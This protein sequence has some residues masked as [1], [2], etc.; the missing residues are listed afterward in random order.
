VTLPL[1]TVVDIGTNTDEDCYQFTLDADAL[2]AADLSGTCTSSED[3]EIFLLDQA[4]TELGRNDDD[5]SSLCSTL[6]LNLAAGTYR[7]CVI[8]HNQD[9]VAIGVDMTITA[10]APAT[11]N[12]RNAPATGSNSFSSTVTLPSG[13]ESCVSVSV[14]AGELLTASAADETCA[15]FGRSYS[16]DV[17]AA[18]DLTTSVVSTF[19]GGGGSCALLLEATVPAGDYVVCFNENNEVYTPALDVQILVQTPGTLPSGSP[20]FVEATQV[21][22]DA[23]NNEQCLS[24]E[25]PNL[26][27]CGV[28]NTLGEGETCVVG[29]TGAVC[30]ANLEC[31]G[32]CL[33][34]DGDGRD[35]AN[36]T[37]ATLPI[38]ASVFT[39]IGDTDCYSFDVA[40]AGDFHFFTTDDAPG[41]GDCGP[42]DD[43]DTEIFLNNADGTFIASDDDGSTTD[44]L[45]SDLVQNLA[46]GQYV[47]C[48]EEHN[49]DEAINGEVRLVVTGP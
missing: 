26:F 18:A 23:A 43:I 41:D 20:C 42:G 1:T 2:V 12:D 21:I 46:A 27:T 35:A 34:D 47:V 30:D 39:P 15:D 3:T 44:G 45:C 32:T 14:A 13:S 8:E 17:F 19:G 9:D 33:P 10:D 5:G 37:A 28:V 16:V 25:T 48:V 4:G 31:R 29:L 24:F 49:R 38:D 6:G 40:A 11:V 7:L 22:C 36:A